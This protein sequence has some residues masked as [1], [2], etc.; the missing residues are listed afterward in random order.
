MNQRHNQLLVKRHLTGSE[1]QNIL[2]LFS[3]H[4]CNTFISHMNVFFLFRVSASV[5]SEN[6]NL[7]LPICNMLKAE[8]TAFHVYESCDFI[9]LLLYLL[10][11]SV[12]YVYVFFSLLLEISTKCTALGI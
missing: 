2:H 4:F 11:V 8:H 12:C 5:I 6:Q 1:K 7:S 10:Y 9:S 3:L